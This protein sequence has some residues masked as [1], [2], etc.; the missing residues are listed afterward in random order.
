ME[1]EYDESKSA[2]NKKKHGVD[3]VEAKALWMDVDRLEIPGFSEDE[4]RVLIIARMEG[5]HWTAVI[6]YRSDRV[7]IISVRRSRDREVSLYES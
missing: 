4:P 5:K 1:F 2:A 3:F 7:R 6:T